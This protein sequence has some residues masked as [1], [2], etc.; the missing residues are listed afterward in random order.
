MVDFLDGTL[1][2]VFVDGQ[3]VAEVMTGEWFGRR[4]PEPYSKQLAL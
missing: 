3:N 2:D 4:G 1:A